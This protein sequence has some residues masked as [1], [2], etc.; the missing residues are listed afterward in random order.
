MANPAWFRQYG[1]GELAQ[2]FDRIVQSWDTANK[3][4]ELSDLGHCRQ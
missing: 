3:A 4:T 2:S 1:P